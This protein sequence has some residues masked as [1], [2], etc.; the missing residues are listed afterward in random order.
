MIKNYFRIVEIVF[1]LILTSQAGFPEGNNDCLVCHS[2]SS[3]TTKRN[4][5]ELSLYVDS[6]IFDS[7]VH[8]ELA[9]VDCHVGFNPDSIPH[10]KGVLTVNCNNC[11]DVKFG[12]SRVERSK[13]A[14][15]KV[16][17]SGCHGT[18]DIYPPE[19]LASAQFCLKCH[20]REKSYLTSRH[21]GVKVADSLFSCESCH[22]KAHK[23]Q[24]VKNILPQDQT[25]MCSTCH[26][27]DSAAVAAGIHKIPLADGVLTCVTCHT[28]HRTVND[29]REISKNACF[30]CHTNQKL[31]K[32]MK[33]TGGV[34]LTSLVEQYS[35]SIHADL[36]NK[37]QKGATCVDCHEGHTIKPAN[38]PTSSVNRANI[39]RTCGKC[40]SDVEEHYLKSSHGKA[41]LHGIKYAPVCTDCH[42]EHSIESIKNP[43]AP[44]SRANE[45]N[46]CLKCHVENKEVLNMTGVSA[47]FL[48]SIK[49]SVHMVALSRGN[50]KAATCSDCHGAHDMLPAGDPDSKVFKNNIPGTCGQAGCHDEVFTKYMK[51]IHGEALVAGNKDAPVC[52]DCHGMHQILSPGNPQSTVSN[53]N[54]A[55]ACS[56]CH[57][58]VQLTSRYKLPSHAVVSYLDSYHGLAMQGGSATVANCASCHGAHDIKPS[59]DPTSP[60]NPKNLASTCGK[61]HPGAD[62]RFVAG[63]VH[64]LP[65]SRKEPLLFWIS[66]IYIVL[67]IGTIGMMVFHNVLDFTK[68]IIRRMRHQR[69]YDTTWSTGYKLYLRMTL[70]ERIQHLLLLLSF[71]TLVVTGF[72]LKFPDS[73]WVKPIRDIF[74]NNFVELRGVIHRVAAV[75]LIADAIYHIFYVIFTERGRK[76]VIDMIPKVQDLRDLVGVFKYNLGLSKEK[77]QLG[78]FSY[79]EKFEYLALIW[80]TVIMGLTGFILWFNNYFLGIVGPIGMDAATLIHYYEAVLASLAILVWHFYFV[81]FNPD[82]YP[83]N[84]ACITGMLS[85]EE[86]FKEHP[87]ELQ[88]LRE[89]GGED[90]IVDNGNAKVRKDDIEGKGNN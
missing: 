89:K 79:I 36:L 67:I 85:E 64:V 90:I 1:I 82:V 86:M 37:N 45:P 65:S 62:K 54:V 80:G 68:K 10:S 46:L 81:I 63:Q 47:A 7:S 11:H 6:K 3:L 23:V 12:T 50:L 55:R 32:G 30:K 59:S 5:K 61:C 16:S 34:Q 9:C 58:S 48:L 60:I 19:K 4:G 14:H 43:N 29:S 28:A 8:G 44:T 42:E 24:V 77:P 70:N 57:G 41:L 15:E 87:L 76:F 31:F 84:P 72:M 39:V 53:V 33:S 40:H 71:I 38:D 2:D 26:K 66:Q 25:R 78:R 83:L 52:T 18:H 69:G 51:G 35:H 27:S 20:Q 49:N 21:S 22:L 56:Q 75:I 17:C 88:R 74:G 13:F 73:W